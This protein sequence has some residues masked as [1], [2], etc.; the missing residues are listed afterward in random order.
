MCGIRQV[1][2]RAPAPQVNLAANKL[3]MLPDAAMA[4][5]AKVSI[6]S[7]ND[8]NLVR[9]GSLEPLKALTELRIFSNNLED[10]PTLCEECPIEVLEIHKNRIS[11]IPED[12]FGRTPALRRIILSN[13]MLSTLPASIG[14]CSQL[15]SLQVSDCKLEKLPSGIVWPLTLETVFLQGNEGLTEL[16]AELAKLPAIKRCNLGSASTASVTAELM[17]LTLD[18]PDGIFWDREGKMLKPEDK[19]K[20]EKPKE[21]EKTKGGGKPSVS[22]GRPASPKGG[23]PASSSGGKV[24]T[25]GSSARG[26]SPKRAGSPARKAGGAK[27]KPK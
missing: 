5:W 13:N 8:N 7:L 2:A 25:G 3:M 1:S 21:K 27:P 18:K 17:S 22:G 9:L 12:Y 20:K 6:L 16:P 4:G 26:G 11:A 14:K 10:M 19:P 15:L 24:S 23:R